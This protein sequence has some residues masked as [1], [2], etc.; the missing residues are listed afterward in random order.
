MKTKFA[1]AKGHYY[2]ITLVT[3]VILYSRSGFHALSI[4]DHLY[5]GYGIDGHI[6]ILVMSFV[7]AWFLGYRDACLSWLY[8]IFVASIIHLVLPLVA[9]IV[10]FQNRYFHG[11]IY[12]VPVGFFL[13]FLPHFFVPFIGLKLGRWL[14]AK[15][16]R[17]DGSA[18]NKCAQLCCH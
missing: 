14:R 9:L 5:S 16:C 6:I 17:G 15:K 12:Y 11:F 10:N 1:N 13:I 4:L 3:A 2:A 18:D 8:P 7:A